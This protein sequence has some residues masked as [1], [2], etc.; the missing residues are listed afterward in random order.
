[1]IRCLARASMWLVLLAAVGGTHAATGE[2]PSDDGAAGPRQSEL[3]E[4][5]KAKAAHSPDGA[6]LN[7]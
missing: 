7:S 4:K 3:V 2:T 1:M 5:R 6:K